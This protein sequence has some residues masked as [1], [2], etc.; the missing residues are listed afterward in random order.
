MCC[1]DLG[2]FVSFVSLCCGSCFLKIV[3]LA[4]FLFFFLPFSQ[5]QFIP[6]PPENA[7]FGDMFLSHFLL[8]VVLLVVIVVT[9]FVDAFVFVFVG[10][11]FQS[12]HMFVYSASLLLFLLIVIPIFSCCLLLVAAS[13]SCRFGYHGFLFLQTFSCSS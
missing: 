8:F 4:V 5:R 12:I 11:I 13:G 10:L 1:P 2:C 6:F 3:G 9:V 7:S